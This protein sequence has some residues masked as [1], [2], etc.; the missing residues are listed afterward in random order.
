M[1]LLLLTGDITNAGQSEEWRQFFELMDPVLLQKTII[2]PGNH[3]L[4]LPHSSDLDAME[5]M[6]EVLRKIR[7][8]RMIAAMN[9]I[10][11]ERAWVFPDGL[12]PIRLR[13]FLATRERGL[14][15]FAEAGVRPRN[16]QNCTLS[17]S[18]FRVAEEWQSELT[19]R[20][21]VFCDIGIPDVISGQIDMLPAKR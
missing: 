1:D 17:T 10:Q 19:A 21:Q 12:E 3:D 6:S 4:N 2:I 15:E 7:L 18:C 9:E 14:K 13:E 5:G 8:I 11:G 16:G 20:G